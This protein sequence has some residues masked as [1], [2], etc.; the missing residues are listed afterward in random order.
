MI[1]KPTKTTIKAHDWKC[2]HY[3][4]Y[5]KYNLK[6]YVKSIHEN[7][8]CHCDLCSY[9]TTRTNYLKDHIN[10][11]P[12]IAI[13]KL[14]ILSETKMCKMTD[15]DICCIYSCFLIILPI[16]ALTIYFSYL[17]AL[18]KIQTNTTVYN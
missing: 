15:D 6:H 2:P 10:F 3:K 1:I 7:L 8:R 17:S 18:Q 12:I 16:T 13:K 4:T 14:V 9:T 11:S 5:Q